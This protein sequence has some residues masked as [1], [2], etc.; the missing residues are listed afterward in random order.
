MLPTSL[1]DGEGVVGFLVAVDDHVGD[2]LEL[3]VTDP[4]ADGLLALV[5]AHP[6]GGLA[7]AVGQRLDIGTVPVRDRE[8]SPGVRLGTTGSVA[9][10]PSTVLRAA[11]V[12][13]MS[14]IGFM[15]QVLLLS[16]SIS[17]MDLIWR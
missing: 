17:I 7:Q 15:G 16:S 1:P 9:R 2:L 13:S 10:A 3:G 11:A 8:S 14:A 4:L 6:D 5:D 12:V